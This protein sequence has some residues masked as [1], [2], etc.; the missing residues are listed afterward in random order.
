MAEINHTV[1]II[2]TSEKRKMGANEEGGNHRVMIMLP[3]WN[4]FVKLLFL[5]QQSR[6][7]RSGEL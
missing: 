4:L 1:V 7:K 3:C 2:F 6:Q 5:N